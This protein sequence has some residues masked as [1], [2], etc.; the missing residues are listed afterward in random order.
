[1]LMKLH[2]LMAAT[3][4]LKRPDVYDVA[5][6]GGGPAGLA[7]ALAARRALGPDAH[8][9]VFERAPALL[10]IGGQVGLINKAFDALDA[11]DP[12]GAA[13]AA[14]EQA[15]ALRKVFRRLTPDGQVEAEMPVAPEAKQC[16]VP[17]YK[18]Q[19]ALAA[20]LPEDTIRLGREFDSYTCEDDRVVLKFRGGET[21]EARIVIGAD[22]NMSRLR[23]ALF[24]DEGPPSYAGSAIWR[25]FLSG[26]FP[27]LEE[28]VSSVWTGDGK[29]LALQ[30][31]GRHADA[32][33]YVSG[34]SAWPEDDLGTLDRRR[35]VGAEDGG[36]SGGR[37]TNAER[38]ARFAEQFEG[39][40]RDVVSF[41]LEHCETASI[42]E[43]P[44]YYREVGRPWGRGRASLVG[45]AAHVI[46]P[47]MAM[48]TPLAFEDA[49][50][51]GHALAAHSCTPDALR[52]YEAVR[53]G[54]VGVI[55]SAAIAQ[56]GRYYKEK[57][58]SANP[59]KLNDH[60]PRRG[61]RHRHDGASQQL[62]AHALRA[63]RGRL[64][65]HADG[66]DRRR[67]AHPRRGPQGLR[68]RRLPALLPPQQVDVVHAAH[69][70][71]QLPQVPGGGGHGL[72]ARL[73]QARAAARPAPRRAE[74][75]R[76]RRV[77]GRDAAALRRG[78][79][80]RARGAAHPRAPASA[81]ARADDRRLVHGRRRGAHAG[82][83]PRARL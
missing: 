59:F 16:V 55:A 50:A 17:W 26:D 32:R 20:L 49:A 22:G 19:R 29:V 21:V 77:A 79:R 73:L 8:V 15:G 78:G 63:R 28:G 13:S 70:H 53:R 1:M 48:G 67:R 68:A 34:Q 41:A 61:P 39:F 2:C 30:K 46:P 65:R 75:E 51:L 45:D 5:I 42:L 40:P 81:R 33:V 4:A 47:N 64:R 71:V 52:A 37:S 57:D 31:M 7:T 35:Y 80:P 38:L 66:V 69:E 24:E 23:A 14:V 54:R 62:R 74:K 83:E 10:E 43:H 3:A 82:A 58:D 36:D 60:G 72:R 18:L 12:S 25:M 9:A 56:T 27:G 6:V 11:V 76:Q 44:I